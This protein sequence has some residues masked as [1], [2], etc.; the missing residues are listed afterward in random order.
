MFAAITSSA[1]ASCTNFT[2]LATC[3]T[4]V[5][6]APVA[7]VV[8]VTANATGITFGANT[9]IQYGVSASSGTLGTNVQVG[10]LDGTDTVRR[11]YALTAIE[12][13]GV[14]AGTHTFYAQATKPGVFSARQAN[15]FDQKMT[16]LFV[17]NP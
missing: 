13:F 1:P 15:I 17:P 2:T 4:I 8:L 10:L 7:G 16:A 12:V 14:S 3:G 6:E 5:V 11:E 9:V